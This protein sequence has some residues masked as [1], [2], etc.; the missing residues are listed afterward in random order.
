MVRKHNA[1][2]IN[3]NVHYN[4]GQEKHFYGYNDKLHVKLLSGPNQMVQFTLT[5]SWWT[6]SWSPHSFRLQ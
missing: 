1:I 3:V 6:Q 5:S 4:S 2:P